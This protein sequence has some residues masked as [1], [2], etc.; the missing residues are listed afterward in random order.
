MY[1][2]CSYKA[3]YRSISSSFYS[4]TCFLFTIFE[5]SIPLHGTCITTFTLASVMRHG[6]GVEEDEVK[7]TVAA[8]LRNLITFLQ[9][10]AN[11]TKIVII[12][13]S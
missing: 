2:L 11:N 10:N 5:T 12:V 6:Q 1:N 7:I 8:K 3:K 9:T 13:N 4:H